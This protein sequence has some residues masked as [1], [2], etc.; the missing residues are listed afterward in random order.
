MK[1]WIV[2]KHTSMRSGKSYIGI[3]SKTM[4][5]RWKEHVDASKHTGYHFHNAIQLYGKDNWTHEI[6]HDNIDTV[7]EAEALEKYCI[8]KYDTFE[9][10][11]NRTSGGAC[12]GAPF[13]RMSEEEKDIACKAISDKNKLRYNTK[14]YTFYNPELSITE[15]LEVVELAKKYGLHQG[16]VRY[17]TQGKSKHC[18]GWFLWVGEN[19]D[20]KKDPEYTFTHDVY[21][22]DQGT[23]KYMAMKYSLSKGNLHGV[24]IGKRNHTKGWKLKINGEYNDSSTTSTSN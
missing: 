12:G 22:E 7:E 24:T 5:Q 1:T 10:G 11:Y 13:S 23:L 2:Y 16:Y 17:V 6:L 15:H 4:E 3:T 18:N 8:K 20:Y 9:N 21:G 14:A 19:G